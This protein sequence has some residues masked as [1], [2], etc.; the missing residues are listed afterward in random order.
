MKTLSGKGFSKLLE[1]K[2]WIL[3]RINGSHHIYKHSLKT[4][5]IS[6]P[7]HKN[8]SLKIGLQKKLMS[9]ADINDSEL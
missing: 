2:G 9:I 5:I 6:L 8:D 4:E 3:K 1:N 7:I